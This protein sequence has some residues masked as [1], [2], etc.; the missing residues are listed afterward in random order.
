M[1]P[2]MQ[3]FTA[4][5][6]YQHRVL[7]GLDGATSHSQLAFKLSRALRDSEH[8]ESTLWTWNADDGAK[9]R[10]LTASAFNAS[11]PKLSPDASQLAFISK[12]GDGGAQVQL[13]PMH[14]GEARQLTHGDKSPSA[15]EGWNP[16]GKK[17][18]LTVEVRWSEQPREGDGDARQR[19]EDNG[20]TRPHV[21]R[22]LPY[23]K[24]RSGVIAGKRVHLY[25]ADAASGEM[26]PLVEGDCD[27]SG[28]SWSPDDAQLAFIRNRSGRQRHRTDVWIADADGGRARQRT[29]ALASVSKAQWSPDGRSLALV[30][31]RID[32]DSMMQLWL[33]DAAGDGAPRRM[34][35]D[36]FELTPESGIVWHADGKRLAVIAAREGLQQVAIVEVDSGAV[37]CLR[38]GLRQILGLAACGERLACTVASMR[39]PDELYSIGWD[40]GDWRRHSSFNRDWAAQRPQPRVRK[41]RFTVP[42]GSGASERVDAWLLLPAQ[43]EGPYPLLVDMHGG[44]QSHVLVDFAMH[45]YWYTLLSQGWAILAPNTVGSGGYGVAFAKRLCGHWGELDFPQHLAIIDTLQ[46]EGLADERIACTGKSYGGYLSAWAIGNSDRFRAAIVS[47]PVSDIQSH[48]GTSDT[49]YYVTPYAMGGE[50]HETS[51]RAHALS[52]VTHCLRVTTPTLLLQGADDGRCPIGQSEQLFANLIRCS[53]VAAELVVYPGGN[54]TL[55]ETGAPSHRVDY[56]QRL[57]DWANRW[58]GGGTPD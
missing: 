40:G 57:C 18:L 20:G 25:S 28:A 9:P 45:T 2:H 54:H 14:G 36:D 4:E 52:P 58:A 13:L 26:Q 55:A 44:P 38:H 21:A 41:R 56:H 33:L 53:D 30:A 50:F 49:G 6:L 35:D 3:E 8:Y 19:S 17:L 39:W 10:Q 1:E 48:A 47:A 16:G 27:V 37:T 7:A 22:Y 15:I 24:D 51:Q 46:G 34:G 29:D 43:G 12:R 32:G 5:D 23:K 11:S 31:G 42:D